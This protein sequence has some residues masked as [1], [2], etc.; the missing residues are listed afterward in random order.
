MGVLLKLDAGI[1]PSVCLADGEWFRASFAV[2][3]AYGH[4]LA[5]IASGHRRC[6]CIKDVRVNS[7]RLRMRRSARPFWKCALTPASE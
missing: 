3:N 6:A 5:V 2:R 1:R 4:R 7:W